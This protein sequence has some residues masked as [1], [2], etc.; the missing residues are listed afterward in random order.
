MTAYRDEKMMLMT[1]KVLVEICNNISTVSMNY[2]FVAPWMV[3]VS[4]KNKGQYT[5]NLNYCQVLDHSSFP[6]WCTG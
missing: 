2:D 6:I 3:N 1:H 5:L 4:V